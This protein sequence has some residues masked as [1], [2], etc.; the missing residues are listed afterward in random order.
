MVVDMGPLESI[1]S[2]PC[3]SRVSWSRLPRTVSSQVLNV[4]KDGDSTTSLGSLYQCSPTLLTIKQNFL[5]FNVYP[6]MGHH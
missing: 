6:I 4:S 5:Y 2:N 3:L 1:Q